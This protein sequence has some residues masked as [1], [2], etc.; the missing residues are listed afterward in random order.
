MLFTAKHAGQL[1]AKCAC[2]GSAEKTCHGTQ[3]LMAVMMIGELRYFV[4]EERPGG[5]TT[6]DGKGCLCRGIQIG[7]LAYEAAG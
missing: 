3:R 7:E 1:S 6:A 4:F 5:Q 2:A